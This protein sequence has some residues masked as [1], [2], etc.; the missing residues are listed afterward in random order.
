[1]SKPTLTHDQSVSLHAALHRYEPAEIIRLHAADPKGWV[2]Y[3]PMNAL[4]TLDLITLASAIT[5][6][7]ET[8]K[9]PI[10]ILRED[11][12]KRRGFRNDSFNDGWCDGV[13]KTLEAT[14]QVVEGINA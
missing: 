4:N 12:R 7:W 2:E 1:M 5:N 6:G 14:G 9:T 3:M 11:Y 10:D 13:R 8:E